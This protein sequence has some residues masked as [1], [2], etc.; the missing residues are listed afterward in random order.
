MKDEKIRWDYKV[1][2]GCEC[3]WEEKL[4][5]NYSEAMK[6]YDD[7]VSHFKRTIK[8]GEKLARVYVEQFIGKGYEDVRLLTWNNMEEYFFNL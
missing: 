8:A 1:V 4:Y 7:N 5:E 3:E 2:I 6:E